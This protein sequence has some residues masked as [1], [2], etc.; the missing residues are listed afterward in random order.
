MCHSMAD[1]AI[2]IIILVSIVTE[3]FFCGKKGIPVLNRYDLYD[4]GVAR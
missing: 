3:F 4:V 1:R 2:I